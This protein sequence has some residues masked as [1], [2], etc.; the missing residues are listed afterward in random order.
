MIH[1][2]IVI[3]LS[4]N[5]RDGAFRPPDWRPACGSHSGWTMIPI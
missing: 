1:Y 5:M 4:F 3:G 2:L